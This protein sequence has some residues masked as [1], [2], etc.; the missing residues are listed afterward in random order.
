MRFLPREE[1]FYALFEQQIEKICEAAE[2]LY[3]GASKGG[4]RL[5]EAAEQIQSLETQADELIH[6][7]FL[8][9]NQTFITPLDP[10]DI[11]E[12]STSL[13]NVIDAIEDSAHRM[14]A[15]HLDPISPVMVHICDMIR[16]CGASLLKAF[17]AFE[18]GEPVLAH[19]IEVNRLE[20]ETD[21]VV[22][23]AIAELFEH[24]TD[25]IKIIK[26][27]EVYEFLEAAT[28]YCEDVT[29]VLQTVVVKNS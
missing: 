27:K 10:E 23:K 6:E 24:E 4:T 26:F 14:V 11:H 1:K 5:T 16:K 19:C 12:L 15:Y 21:K 7:V 20:N 13:D 18:K 22:R 8:R 9:L 29:D 2:V 25:P 3:D 17:Q 28:D